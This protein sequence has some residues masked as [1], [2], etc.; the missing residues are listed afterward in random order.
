MRAITTLL[1]LASRQ[2]VASPAP[3]KIILFVLADDVGG[4]MVGWAAGSTVSRGGPGNGSFTPRLDALAAEGLILDNAMA[5]FWCTP[6]RSSFLTG[7]LPVHVQSGQD[8]PET[9]HAGVPRYMGSLAAKLGAA[10]IEPHVVGKWDLGMATPD[11]TPEG[12]GFNS[13]LIYWEHMSE[14]YTQKIFP[15]GTACTLYDPTIS[16][17]WSNGGPAVGL[18]GTAFLEYLHRDRLDAL[19]SSWDGERPLFILYAPHVAHYPLQVPKDW[20]DRYAFM[21]N[22]EG[23]CNA[24]VPYVYPGAPPGAPMRC[25]AQGAALMGLL[26][27]I[28]GNYTDALKARGVWDDTLVIFQSDNGAPLD[29]NEAGGGNFPL[30]GG[31]YSSWQGGVQT[32]AF[33]AGGYLPAARR[34]A[35]EAGLTHIADWWA[36]LIGL[37]GGDPSDARAAAHGLPPPDALDL[38]PLLSGING[39]SPRVEVPIAPSSLISWPWKFLKGPQ[40][41]SGW[42]GPLYPNASS[43][44]QS[45]NIWEL[46][47]EGCLFD[48]ASDPGEHQNVAAAN[49]AIVRALSA[50]IDALAAGFWSNNDTGVDAC[51]PGTPLCGC[52]AAVHTWGGFLGPYQK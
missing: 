20:L 2:S 27:S 15:G 14:Q 44:A 6:S 29:V 9:P 47:G 31:K 46:C 22:D 26:D 50:R 13:S 10:G 37:A 40:W 23:A 36:T 48:L 28:V 51:P 8:F 1:L 52:W 24:T 12:R 21:G 32:P 38:W 3:P 43:P 18:N 33:V 45:P 7:R 41:W 25:R 42:Q 17:L 19:L 34:G 5:A 39:T 11:H 30:R 49:P 4:N 35:R 16:D